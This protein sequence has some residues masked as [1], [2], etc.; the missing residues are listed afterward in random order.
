MGDKKTE[1]EIIYNYKFTTTTI[2]I[3]DHM[4]DANKERTKM[5]LEYIHAQCN[6]CIYVNDIEHREFDG[7]RYLN[8]FRCI[9]TA[10]NMIQTIEEST[11]IYPTKPHKRILESMVLRS[12]LYNSYID[13]NKSLFMSHRYN[14]ESDKKC[15]SPYK[16]QM[17]K[18]ELFPDTF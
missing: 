13:C 10:S 1:F 15:Y 14:E 9:K 18:Y 11:K 4:D 6:K 3:M 2:L 12:R 7:A 8:K 16:Q 5:A 17:Q